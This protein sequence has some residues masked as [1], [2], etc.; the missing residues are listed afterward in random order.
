MQPNDV[1][2]CSV[3]LSNASELSLYFGNSEHVE[4]LLFLRLEWLFPNALN[5]TE[6]C[7]RAFELEPKGLVHVYYKFTPPSMPSQSIKPVASQLPSADHIGRQVVLH[8]KVQVVMG[9][10]LETRRFYKPIRCARCSEFVLSG[11]ALQCQNCKF[12]CHKRCKDALLTECCKAYPE[13]RPPAPIRFALTSHSWQQSSLM[14]PSWCCHCGQMTPFGRRPGI[15]QCTD[16]AKVVHE[17][18]SRCV[19]DH[20]GFAVEGATSKFGTPEMIESV[21]AL[22]PC[23]NLNLIGDI[24]DWTF[25]AVLG[26]GNF[27][28]VRAL[29]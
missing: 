11:S 7:N 3:E 8:R 26:R 5:C 1:L 15:K 6:E 21:S 9:H 19:P 14:L 24:A 16:C 25:M 22:I 27:G 29:L 2:K 18:C 17:D 10:R 4:S 28:K 20:C 12:L 13:D 23:R